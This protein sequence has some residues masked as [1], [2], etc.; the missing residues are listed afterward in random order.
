MAYSQ[1]HWEDYLEQ[2][3]LNGGFPTFVREYRFLKPRRFRFDFAWPEH[4]IA[5]EMH[6][7]VW[8]G[9]GHVTGAGYSRDREKMNLA[10]IDGWSVFE[11]TSGHVSNGQAIEWLDTY[12]KK[13][14]LKQ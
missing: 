6:G 11:V 10:I 12:F 13:R 7:G 5:A 3:L 9:G 8:S 4:K 14:G 1:K 2:E